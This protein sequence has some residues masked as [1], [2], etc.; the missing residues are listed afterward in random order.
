MDAD[1]NTVGA[2]TPGLLLF[3]GGTVCN[4]DQ[5]DDNSCAAAC[6]DLGYTACESWFSGDYWSSQSSLQITMAKFQCSRGHWDSCSHSSSHNCD[7]SDDVFLQCIEK[8][9]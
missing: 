5:F 1:G 8:P 6:R 2:H 7:H 3:K 4:D 9:G